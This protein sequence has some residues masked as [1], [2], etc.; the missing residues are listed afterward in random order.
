MLINYFLFS[1]VGFGKLIFMSFVGKYTLEQHY[2]D[3]ETDLELIRVERRG[4]GSIG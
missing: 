4:A 3:L 2:S 1:F